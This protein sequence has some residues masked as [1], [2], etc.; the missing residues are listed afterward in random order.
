MN[1]SRLLNMS[2][3]TL[4]RIISLDHQF[5]PNPWS[6][7]DWEDL[8]LESYQLYLIEFEK[9]ICG[10]ALFSVSQFDNQAHLLKIL[11]EPEKRGSGLAKNALMHCFESLKLKMVRSIYLEV[12]TNNANAMGLYLS[13][14]F[15]KL[16]LKKRFY[17]NGEDAYAMQK[18]LIQN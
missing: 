2:N 13:L 14:G 18:F 10:F 15:E 11:V 17:S 12:A 7:K 6:R 9:K 5:F 3:D 4:L 16:V 1:V 8:D